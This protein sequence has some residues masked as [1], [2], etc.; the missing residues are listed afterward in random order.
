[1]IAGTV[2]VKVMVWGF[3]IAPTLSASIEWIGVIEL[4]KVVMNDVIGVTVLAPWTLSISTVTTN[5]EVQLGMGWLL[6]RT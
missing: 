6:I 5:R 3:L 1:M 4:P 2:I